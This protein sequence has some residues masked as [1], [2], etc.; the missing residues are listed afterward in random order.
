MDFLGALDV[1]HRAIDRRAVLRLAMSD[2][3]R[4][5]ALKCLERLENEYPVVEMIRPGEDM[6]VR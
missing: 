4:V 3:D 6:L 2:D 1:D 5:V